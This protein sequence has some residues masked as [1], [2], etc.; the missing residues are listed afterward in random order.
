MG[1]GT[2]S[3]PGKVEAS[4]PTHRS[5]PS[6]PVYIPANNH[7]GWQ[8]ALYPSRG[9]W[10]PGLSAL[11]KGNKA[12]MHPRQAE[13]PTAMGPSLEEGHSLEKPGWVG[14][15]PFLVQGQGSLLGVTDRVTEKGR[16][17]SPSSRPWPR[18]W[19]LWPTTPVPVCTSGVSNVAGVTSGGREEMGIRVSLRQQ[20]RD[21]SRLRHPQGPSYRA[22]G[23]LGTSCPEQSQT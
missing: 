7:H 11:W 22:A 8:L 10:N 2:I 19:G 17:P 5:Q 18:P 14:E 16:S 6:K 20:C 15:L 12:T 13:A 4:S 1:W 9:F 21:C 23:A 3:D